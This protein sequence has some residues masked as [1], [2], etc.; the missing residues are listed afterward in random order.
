MKK[1]PMSAKGAGAPPKK[2]PSGS[3][4]VKK[5]KP[6]LREPL[7]RVVRKESVEKPKYSPRGKVV[8]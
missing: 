6:K 8:R 3:T 4:Q 7:G 1:E 2:S 5:E